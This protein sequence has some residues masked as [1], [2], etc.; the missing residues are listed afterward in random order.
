MQLALPNAR[1]TL[2]KKK[3]NSGVTFVQKLKDYETENK[4]LF[5]LMLSIKNG[6]IRNAYSI[7]VACWNKTH[8]TIEHACS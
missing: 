1:I 5:S 3:K 4:H 2:N 7:M 6:K 8:I